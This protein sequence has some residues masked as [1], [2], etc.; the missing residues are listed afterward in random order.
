MLCNA[1]LMFC[2]WPL[3]VIVCSL[4]AFLSC[5]IFMKV[6]VFATIDFSVSPFFPIMCPMY[7]LLIWICVVV[8][9]GWVVV[10]VVLGV[11]W[12]AWGY[13]GVGGVASSGL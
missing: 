1:C 5:S 7:S 6:F 13:G 11:L 10:G 3:M 2:C 8:A 12:V 4:L 9:S